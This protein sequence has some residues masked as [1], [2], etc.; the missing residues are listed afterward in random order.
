MVQKTLLILLLMVF[1]FSGCQDNKQAKTDILGDWESIDWYIKNTGEKVN[2]KM[3]F[4][5]DDAS[6][7]MVDYGS[8]KE[9]GSYYIS[10]DKL[11]TTETGQKEKNVKIVRLDSDT[12]IFE[13][14][15]AGSLELIVLSK[16]K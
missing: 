14:N 16:R 3:D 13:M 12:M 10:F 15:R 9:E 2:Q 5:F 11:Y 1:V 4:S 7:Y 8:Q 6:N